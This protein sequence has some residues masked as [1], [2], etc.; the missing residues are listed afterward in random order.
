MHLLTHNSEKTTGLTTREIVIFAM[1][2]SIMYLSKVIMEWIPNVHLLGVLT[3]SYT[4]VYRKKA[5]V[6]IYIYVLLNG[7]L[8][9]FSPW[10]I[11]YLY[12][13]T[14]L[15]GVTM[16][17]PRN[18]GRNVKAVVYMG[19]CGLHGLFFGILYAPVQAILFGL[20][21]EGMIAWIIAG[22]PYDFIHGIGNVCA[23]ILIIPV[24]KLLRKLEISSQ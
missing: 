3:M 2:A 10:W 4:L 14:I 23:G 13:W 1:L 17:L 18:L 24:V 15:W 12:I 8:V 19:I 6:P 22:L 16:M 11:P 7:V 20:S 9:G 21:M 5:L